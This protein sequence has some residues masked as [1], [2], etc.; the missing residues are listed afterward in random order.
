MKRKTIACEDCG[1]KGLRNNG[2]LQD[3]AFASLEGN[4][5]CYECFKSET[6]DELYG[7]DPGLL[8]LE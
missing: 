6:L 3:R 7:F 2:S 1:K 8:G 5:V 4:T